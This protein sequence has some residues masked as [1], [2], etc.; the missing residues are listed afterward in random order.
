VA[1]TRFTRQELL[2]LL[3]TKPLRALAPEIGVSDARLKKAARLAGLSTPPLGHWIKLAAGKKSAVKPALPPRG[4]GAP[5][6]IEFGF[7]EWSYPPK[8]TPPAPEP[9]DA[10]VFDESMEGV[11]ERAVRA[12]GK[13][14][15]ARDLKLPHPLVRTLLADDAAIAEKAKTA[16]SYMVS[17]YPVRYVTSADHRKLRLLSALALGLARAEIKVE[18]WRAEQATIQ[19]GGNRGFPVSVTAKAERGRK[20]PEAGDRQSIV[21]GATPS[22]GGSVLAR[23]DDD[24]HRRLEVDITEI[25]VDIVVLVEERYRQGRLDHHKWLVERWVADVEEARKAKEEAERQERDRIE[26]LE[27]DRIK[28]LLHDADRLRQADAIRAYVAEAGRRSAGDVDVEAF[29]RWRRWALEQ[30]NRIDPLASGSF[31]KAIDDVG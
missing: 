26:K 16:P 2:D 30:A 28:R 6:D 1:I 9:P 21:V 15:V 4:F 8:K 10:P 29:D 20:P 5:E 23:W 25:V 19:V 7:E 3:W 17:S 18:V 12:V 31:L 22:H 14:T 13:I 27:R 11:R 24:A